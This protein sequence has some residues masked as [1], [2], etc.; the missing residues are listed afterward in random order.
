MKEAI[1]Q[2]LG[3]WVAGWLGGWVGGWEGRQQA[4]GLEA[5]KEDS[6]VPDLVP[7]GVTL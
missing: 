7:G 3:A 5:P 1:Y 4:E 6:H 2:G